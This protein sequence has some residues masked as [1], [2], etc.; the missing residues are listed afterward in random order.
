MPSIAA[1][2]MRPRPMPAPMIVMAMPRPPP[3]ARPEKTVVC[4]PP[5][6]WARTGA[7]PRKSTTSARQANFASFMAITT[8][9]QLPWW[10]AP[11]VFSRRIPGARGDL[12][13]SVLRVHGH[14]HEQRGQE[15]ENVRLQERDENLQ[16]AEQD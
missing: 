16:Q 8:P 3:I 4:N 15:H 6:S 11:T 2:P 1:A 9:E 7:A 13:A 14:A 5:A 10:A 12:A